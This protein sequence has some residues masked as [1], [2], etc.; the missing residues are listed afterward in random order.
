MQ[1]DGHAD[2]WKWTDVEQCP[3]NDF[4]PEGK[5]LHR[6]VE[7][8]AEDHDMFGARLLAGFER[9]IEN[10]Y[11]D[12]QEAPVNSWFGYYTMAGTIW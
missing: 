12:L 5:A 7:E 2:R 8:M 3:L 1:H 10:G 9:M 11:E 6:I 4:T